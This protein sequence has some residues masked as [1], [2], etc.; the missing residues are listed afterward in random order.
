[1]ERN[2]LKNLVAFE[3]AEAA[4]RSGRYLANGDR[5][6]ARSELMDALALI[7]GLRQ[8]VAGWQNDA[9]LQ[10]DE[11]RLARFVSELDA[12]QTDMLVAALEY[13]A[14]RKLLPAAMNED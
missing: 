5:A 1:L 11:Q 7:T 13:A 3:T 6:T 2:V 4:R 8:S 10:A 9:E 12:G 14:Y